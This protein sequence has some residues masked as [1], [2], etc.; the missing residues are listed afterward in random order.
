M[1]QSPFSYKIAG[2]KSSG[3]KN[4]HTDNPSATTSS[5]QHGVPKPPKNTGVD[6][7][8]KIVPG[9]KE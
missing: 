2:V 7:A 4:H 1:P 6:S 9:Y 3:P 8:V 5:K